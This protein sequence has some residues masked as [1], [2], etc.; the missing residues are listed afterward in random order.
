MNNVEQILTAVQAHCVEGMQKHADF[1]TPADAE[2]GIRAQL[3][4]LAN[5]N[6]A[7]NCADNPAQVARR[8]LQV[9][10][11]CVKALINL[12]STLPVPDE[13][14]AASNSHPEKQSA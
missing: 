5:V 3:Q 8:L 10:G 4:K 11:M 14:R 9:A 13:T 1:A 2:R 7:P 12:D 6:A